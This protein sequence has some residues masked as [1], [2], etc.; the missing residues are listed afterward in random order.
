MGVHSGDYDNDGDLDLFVTNFS[1]DYNT[2][3]QNQSP[4]TTDSTHFVDVSHAT[5]L[6]A[7]DRPYLGWATAFWITTTMAGWIYM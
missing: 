5:G 1:E 6:S 2:L 3:Y 4:P 7:G